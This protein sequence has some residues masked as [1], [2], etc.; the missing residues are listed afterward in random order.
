MNRGLSS[1]VNLDFMLLKMLTSLLGMTAYQTFVHQ[2]VSC[3]AAISRFSIMSLR[4]MGF[5]YLKSQ[6]GLQN[7]TLI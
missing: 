1:T 2:N 4:D 6:V 7:S 3:C 5:C